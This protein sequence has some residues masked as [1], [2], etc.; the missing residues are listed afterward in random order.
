MGN[1]SEPGSD[2]FPDDLSLGEINLPTRLRRALLNEG[3]KTVGDVRDLS[4]INLRCLRRIGD[5]SFRIL[6]ELLGPSRST[7]R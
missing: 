6:R 1:Q 5:D 3:L 2:R 7:R 4:D